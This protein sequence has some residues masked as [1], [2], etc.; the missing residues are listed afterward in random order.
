MLSAL[1]DEAFRNDRKPGKDD[2]TEEDS[3]VRGLG[4]RAPE[5]T[6]ENN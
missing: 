3:G 4:T 1:S 2:E 6:R 5:M